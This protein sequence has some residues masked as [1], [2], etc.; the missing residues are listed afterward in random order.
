[1][2]MD[3]ALLR[4][5]CLGGGGAYGVVL[6]Q[7]VKFARGAPAAIVRS[8]CQPLCPQAGKKASVERELSGP[9]PTGV[10][11]QRAGRA[12]TGRAPATCPALRPAA[13]PPID[14]ARR[15]CTAPPRCPPP[16]APCCAPPCPPTCARG[17]GPPASVVSEVN[18]D[19]GP[20]GV[21]PARNPGTDCHRY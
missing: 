6:A 8:T 15:A 12:V 17:R 13:R 2:S 20:T 16:P 4:G 14:S 3:S 21:Y 5:A 11:E 18:C 10:R 19:D 9:A 1:M 7:E